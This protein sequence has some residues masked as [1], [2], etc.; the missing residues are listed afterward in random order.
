MDNEAQREMT[1]GEKIVGVDFNPAGDTKVKRLKEIFAEAV[2]I[3]SDGEPVTTVGG[4]FYD[5]AVSQILL[6][7]MA[8]VKSVTNR[9]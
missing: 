9:K 8:S 3:I 1:F 2:D 7:Q 5:T 6:A 4:I